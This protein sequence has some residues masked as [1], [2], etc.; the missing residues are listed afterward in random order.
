MKIRLHRGSLADSMDTVRDIEPTVPAVVAYLRE[1]WGEL[2]G[3]IEPQDV[4]VEPYCYDARTGWYT[5]IVTRKG[6]A[7]G[8]TDG[9][10]NH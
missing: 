10:L 4:K 5:H 9:P 6:G 3:D 2:G 1:A 8:F 7:V